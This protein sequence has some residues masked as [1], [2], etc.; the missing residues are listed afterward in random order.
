[1][2]AIADPVRPDVPDAIRTCLN[3]GIDVK[4]V[5]GDNAL[6]ALEIGRQVGLIVDNCTDASMI[7]GDEFQSLTDEELAERI[8]DLKILSRA[9]PADKERLVRFLK[10]Q[11]QVV[12]VTGDGTNDAPALNV[13][14]VGL[15]MGDGTAVAKEASDMTILDNSFHTIADAVKWVKVE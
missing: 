12:A 5:T 8:G 11:G 7:T 13:A 15:S 2:F 14:N 4:I 6:T 9:R 1:M 3:A 10:N